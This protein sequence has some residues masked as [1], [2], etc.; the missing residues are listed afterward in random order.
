MLAAGRVDAFLFGVGFVA[1]QFAT[2]VLLTLADG[3]LWP[4]R[5]ESTGVREVVEVVFGV[6]L[7]AG[8]LVVRRRGA[9]Q[10][11]DQSPLL[12]RLR[13]LGPATALAGGALLGVGGP[14]R[15]VLT[16]LA[17]TAIAESGGNELALAVAYTAVAT[18]LVWGPVAAF[19]LLGDRAVATLEAGQAWLARHQRIVAST[20]LLLVGTFAVADGLAALL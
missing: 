9:P 20:S 13:R 10:S 16:A 11:K 17:A 12:E 15:L 19:E 18:F 1:A 2:C 14:K 7:V 4:G 5:G 6:L 3:A 8:G